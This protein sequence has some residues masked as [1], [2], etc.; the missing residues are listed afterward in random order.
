[1]HSSWIIKLPSNAFRFPI[2]HTNQGKKKGKEK[3]KRGR[4]EKREFGEGGMGSGNCH[5]GIY[6][7]ICFSFFN[8][9]PFISRSSPLLLCTFRSS[10]RGGEREKGGGST[11]ERVVCYPS[12]VFTAA[13]E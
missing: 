7:L 12:S 4:K 10:K 9:P 8:L 2:L 13:F 3:K 6:K 5:H 11:R 1:V